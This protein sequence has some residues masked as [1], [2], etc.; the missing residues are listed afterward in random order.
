MHTC[1]ILKEKKA[2]CGA[3]G[4]RIGLRMRKKGSFMYSLND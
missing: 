2:T 4:S 1:F 3:I